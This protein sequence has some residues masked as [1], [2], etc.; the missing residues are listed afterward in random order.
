[1]FCCVTVRSARILAN[2]SIFAPENNA[3]YGRVT[4]F[5][6]RE[7]DCFYREGLAKKIE[8]ENRIGRLCSSLFKGCLA[9]CGL[10]CFD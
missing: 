1:M 10:Y 4:I 9:F 8:E 7:I 3:L 6:I 2:G 5:N